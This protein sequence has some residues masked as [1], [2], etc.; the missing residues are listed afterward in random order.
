MVGMKDE[1][2]MPNSGT[3]GAP[4][5][6][7]YGNHLVAGDGHEIQAKSQLSQMLMASSPRS[8]V[9]TSLGSNML[10]FSTSVAPPP[11]ELRSHHQS[12]NSSEVNNDMIRMLIS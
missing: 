9:T 4:S 6:S 11:P 2:S 5:Y 10:D 3:G 12:D 7:F 1:G 8:C